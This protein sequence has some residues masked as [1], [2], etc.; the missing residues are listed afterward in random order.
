[1]STMGC[2]AA[3]TMRVIA[4]APPRS[5]WWCRLSASS[6]IT[7]CRPPPVPR[8]WFAAARPATRSIA[9][10]VRTSE[11]FSSI[12]AHPRSAASACAAEVLPTPGEPWI[13]TASPCSAHVSAHSASASRAA[14]LPRTAASVC[15]R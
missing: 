10:F 1:M 8:V 2:A 12:A 6:T 14:S 3:F 11:A 5:A 15:G 13:T 7:S 9:S 4:A